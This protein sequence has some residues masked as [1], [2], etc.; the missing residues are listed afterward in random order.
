ML[1]QCQTAEEVRALARAVHERRQQRDKPRQQC[2]AP[3]VA[4]A[5][6]P[7]IEHFIPPAPVM[8][9]GIFVL[10]GLA[11]QAPPTIRSILEAVSQRY[12]IPVSDIVSRRRTQNVARPRQIAMYLARHLT[13]RS[14]P[15]IGRH[16]GQRDHTTILSGL[17]K[18]DRLR[19]ANPE[20]NA[21]LSELTAI[22][23]PA[24]IVGTDA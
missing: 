11:L 5:P 13:P 20:F 9:R 1:Q 18:I 12:E 19:A 23:K 2:E 15:E 22:L 16:I 24:P 4:V 8:P 17:R 7:V 21:E 10:G 14:L 6:E 3:A